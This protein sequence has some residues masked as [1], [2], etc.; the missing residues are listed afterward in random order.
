MAGSKK[1][2]P[3]KKSSYKPS[4]KTAARAETVYR[5]R[6]DKRW[7]G[8]LKRFREKC[9]EA[10]DG[11]KHAFARLTGVLGR[12]VSGDFYRAFGRVYIPRDRIDGPIHR[13]VA[14]RSR[15]PPY[16]RLV[17]SDL[18]AFAQELELVEDPCKKSSKPPSERLLR[19]LFGV[20]QKY[21]GFIVTWGAANCRRKLSTAAADFARSRKS[22]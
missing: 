7:D 10:E 20:Q 5:Q 21:W 8:G 11:K 15:H 4:P 19:S 16:T 1:A 9:K 12:Y 18:L 6:N 14:H 22:K 17:V 3:K 2:A 13:L